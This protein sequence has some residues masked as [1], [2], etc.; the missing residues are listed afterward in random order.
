MIKTFKLLNNWNSTQEDLC[1]EFFKQSQNNLG[2]WNNIQ[3]VT[4]NNPDYY[5]ILNGLLTDKL[6]CECN[7]IILLQMEPPFRLCLDNT[8][9]RTFYFNGDT[10]K[11]EHRNFDENNKFKPHDIW[12]SNNDNFFSTNILPHYRQGYHWQLQYNYNTLINFSPTKTK[13][14]SSI[15]CN[16]TYIYGHKKRVNFLKYLDKINVPID[17]FGKKYNSTKYADQNIFNELKNYKGS[18]PRWSAEQGLDSYK[19]TFN[20]ENCSEINYYTEKVNN[21]ILCECLLFYWGCPNLENYIDSRAFIRL[22]IDKPEESVKIIENSIKNNE[23][24]KRIDIIRNEKKK[25]L[26]KLQL[27]P[28][29]EN[30]INDNK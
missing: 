23:W 5:V 20:A 14:L 25:I 1:K 18:L 30:I 26:N 19:Y 16:L 21:S 13:V 10:N 7:K 22:D 9:I 6:P 15:I 3:M 29:I 12:L 8:D 4:H 28:T 27:F 11:L 17:I 2:K 24:E